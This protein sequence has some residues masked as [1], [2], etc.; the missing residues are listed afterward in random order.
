MPVIRI[1]PHPA[2]VID[3]LKFLAPYKARVV[4][5]KLFKDIQKQKLT[6]G[7]VRGGLINF[8]PLIESFPQYMALNL[9]KVP[10]GDNLQN[11][12]T[13]YWLITNINQERIHT[14]WWKQWAR[15]FG[16]P[17]EVIET[18]ICPPAEMDCINHYLWS[19]CTRG[20]IA[21]G[22]AAANFAVEGPTG[23]WAKIVSPSMRE[24]CRSHR[25][26]SLNKTLEW[27]Q[28]HADHDDKHPAQ[29]L[30]IIKAYATSA[31]EQEKVRQA[32]RLSL[33]YYAMALD[34]CYE[35]SC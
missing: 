19:I 33:E 23:E 26:K 27:L 14:R 17:S 18:K 34:A 5:N 24:F 28:A 6:L 10:S 9:A 30:E 25:V 32:A 21:E 8:Y 35:L 29:A 31:D 13:R 15:G 16:I 22:I 4:K 20:S 11:S 3:L 1:T 7:Q 12:K 2:W